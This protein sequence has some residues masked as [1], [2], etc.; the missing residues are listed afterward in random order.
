ME[1]KEIF[2]AYTEEEITDKVSAEIENCLKNY[3]EILLEWQSN[4]NK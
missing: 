4:S 3:F 1:T 2:K